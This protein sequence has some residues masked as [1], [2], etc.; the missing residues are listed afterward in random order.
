MTATDGRYDELAD[1][2]SAIEDRRK[3]RLTD[4][5]LLALRARNLP[6]FD[7]RSLLKSN[8]E[9]K[10]VDDGAR[11]LLADEGKDPDAGIATMDAWARQFTPMAN[12]KC[13]NCGA[14]QGGDLIQ[15]AFGLARFTWGLAH[16][17]GHCADCGYPARAYH[18]DLPLFKG[19][20]NL[21]LQYH[22]D[23]L[24]TMAE[25]DR[26]DTFSAIG[27]SSGG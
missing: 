8:A 23:E 1:M 14:L 27:T 9:G 10:S 22:P 12:G 11:D 16:G 24:M 25:R 2:E 4:E 13:I 20:A 18:Y 26:R 15:S 7:W 3:R 6:R 17:S 21:I 5:R 19:M